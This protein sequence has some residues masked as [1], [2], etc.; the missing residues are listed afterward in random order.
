M[1]AREQAV[2][3]DMGGVFNV[4]FTQVMADVGR[5]RGWPMHALPLGP[6]GDVEDPEYDAMCRGELEEADYLERCLARLRAEGI[7]FDP[8]TD[9]DWDT[10]QRPE[11]WD[12]VR[13]IDKADRVQGILTNDASRWL[14]SNW[15]ETWE[16]AA[17]F[18]AVVDVATLGARKPDPSVYIAAAD[19]IDRAPETC[20]FVDDMIVN[21]RGA[22]AVGMQSLLF[23]IT[24]PAASITELEER[25]DLR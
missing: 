5:D 20:I 7:Q 14:G 25:M 17:M 23:E 13:R 4:Y 15:W 8:R 24:K 16:P 1:S 10:Y 12:M 22:E 11:T 9:V 2:V 6:T 18:A 3:W 21:C 19:A